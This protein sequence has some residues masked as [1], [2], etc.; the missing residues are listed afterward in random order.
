MTY[1]EALEYAKTVDKD[2]RSDTEFKK[3]VKVFPSDGSEF[4][5]MDAQLEE[6]DEWIIVYTEHYRYHVFEKFL[7]NS[8]AET[9]ENDKYWKKANKVRLYR[10][11]VFLKKLLGISQ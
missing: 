4:I 1:K 5:W 10:T 3:V 11:K 8:Y 6:L 2:L 7:L 9:D